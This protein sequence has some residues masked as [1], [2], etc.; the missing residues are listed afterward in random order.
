MARFTIEVRR[1]FGCVEVE[2]GDRNG[3]I[4]KPIEIALTLAQAEWLGREMLR[5]VGKP[6]EDCGTPHVVESL[7]SG[8]WICG[9]CLDIDNAEY[10]CQVA[11]G[12]TRDPDARMGGVVAV[13]SRCHCGKDATAVVYTEV[14]G[15]EDLCRPHAEEWLAQLH[16]GQHAVEHGELCPD[17]IADA[18]AIDSP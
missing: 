5:L 6:C 7:H 16:G 2:I 11:G 17:C 4:P 1:G 15:D 13:G 10:A 9:K 8:R 3:H 18:D 12:P 14:W